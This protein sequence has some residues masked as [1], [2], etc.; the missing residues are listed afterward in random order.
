M[1][2]MRPVI[3]DG[4][5]SDGVVVVSSDGF[6]PSR[7]RFRWGCFRLLPSVSMPVPILWAHSH[8]FSIQ[9]KSRWWHTTHQILE[10][11][12]LL[13]ESIR[14]LLLPR[15]DLL[16][17]WLHIRSAR[18]K[19]LQN[20]ACLLHVSRIGK[21]ALSLALYLSLAQIE[22]TCGLHQ[23]ADDVTKLLRM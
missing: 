23:K 5:G 11:C 21:W 16:P 15:A 1:L 7:S 3:D 12:D 13:V 19:G 9:S 4:Y 17:M 10:C 18:S 20:R 8:Q 6:Q 2:V 14:M 22:S